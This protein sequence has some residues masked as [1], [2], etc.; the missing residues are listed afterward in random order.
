[1]NIT[2]GATLTIS[3]AG[4]ATLRKEPLTIYVQGDVTINGAITL[5]GKGCAESESIYNYTPTDNI[6]ALISAGRTGA[7]SGGQGYAGLPFWNFQLNQ[8]SVILNAAGGG[9]GTGGSTGGAGG[10]A[11]FIKC[12]GNL[13]LGAGSTIN[14]GGIAGSNNGAGSGGGGGGGGDVLI[15]YNGTYTNNGVTLTTTGGAGGTGISGTGGGGGA[16]SSA[17]GTPGGAGTSAGGHGGAGFNKIQKV[18]TILW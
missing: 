15:F 16:S 13:V 9:P 10:C 3:A 4:S 11:L 17:D 18:D 14:T 5:T 8:K 1:M 7:F 12:G 2:L 6:T